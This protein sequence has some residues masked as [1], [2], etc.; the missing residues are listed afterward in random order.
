VL[1][2]T[3]SLGAEIRATVRLALPLVLT[4]LAAISVNVVEIGMAG[5]L[6]AR[7]MGAVAVGAN[8]WFF[9]V[10][11]LM[12]VM[13]ALSPNVA[14]LDGG[15]RRGEAAGLF[16]QS[17]WL[18]GAVG[19]FAFVVMQIGAPLVVRGIG[20]DAGLAD[21]ALAFIRSSSWGAPAIAGYE[22][23]RGLTEGLSMPR[24]SLGFGLLGIAV[25]FPAGWVLLFVFG[26]GAEGMG[27]AMTFTAW[28]QFFG[29]LAFIRRSPR[30]RDLDWA[31]GRRGP[32]PAV[33]WGLFRLGGPMAVSLLMESGLF[34]ST[35][36]VIGRFGDVAVAGHQIALSVAS[37]TFMVPLGFAI[38]T[39]VRVGNAVGQ[40]DYG[41]VRRAAAIG[42][43]LALVS[44]LGATAL[45]LSVP[46]GIAGLYAVDPAVVAFGGGLL[47]LAA[48]FQLSD[49]AQCVAAAALRG[50]KDTQGP[51]LITVVAYWGVGMPVGLWLTFTAAWGA[52][53]MWAG[54]IAGLS[55]AAVLLWW[56]FARLSA[57][58]LQGR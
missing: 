30:Y 3:A 19:V 43:A 26:M 34:N 48:L 2:D 35:A 12:G 24:P 54:L 5:R 52:P 33:L 8:V 44:Q 47:F 1:S 49:G 13:M 18:A 51:M 40:G 16:R 36:L 53:G 22:G 55:A 20:I 25:L 45:M 58:L 29:F 14:Q 11:G 32:D 15:G 6:D 46:Y 57:R 41:K 17:L 9:A 21:D 38:A 56:R 31:S 50:L 37:V 39:S 4:Q 10:M 28:V 27:W 7:V 23:C 42:L